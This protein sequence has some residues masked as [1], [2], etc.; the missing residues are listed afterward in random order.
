MCYYD[1]NEYPCECYKWGHFRQH[2]SKEYRTGETCGMKLIMNRYQLQEK[3]KLCLKIETKER[4]IS[5]QKENVRR[6]RKE[7]G[8]KASI[9]KAE[10]DMYRLSQDVYRLQCERDAKRDNLR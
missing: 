9:E 2:C 8:R 7:S 1:I 10:E 6:W 5:K 4:T 3:C